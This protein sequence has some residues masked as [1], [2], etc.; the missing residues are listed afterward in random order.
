MSFYSRSHAAAVR[1]G[2]I[3]A[4]AVINIASFFFIVSVCSVQAE[5][6]DDKGRRVVT[7]VVVQQSRPTTASRPRRPRT[8]SGMEAVAIIKRSMQSHLPRVAKNDT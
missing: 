8:T 3:A 2:E 7:K 4:A 5:V 6:L 1:V